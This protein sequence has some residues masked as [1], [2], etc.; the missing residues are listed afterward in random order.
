M[1]NPASIS[2]AKTN[3]QIKPCGGEE[4]DDDGRRENTVRKSEYEI[5]VERKRGNRMNEYANLTSASVMTRRNHA[6]RCFERVIDEPMLMDMNRERKYFCVET[7]I[8]KGVC[9]LG[10]VPK[11]DHANRRFAWVVCWLSISVSR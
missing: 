4:G 1:T 6:G 10:G 8:P 3:I 9:I 7:L 5:D 2:L 11:V